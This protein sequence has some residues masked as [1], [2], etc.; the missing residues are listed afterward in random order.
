MNLG[1]FSGGAV[2]LS[3][4]RGTF[5]MPGAGAPSVGYP[6]AWERR[7][8]GVGNMK[9]WFVLATAPLLSCATALADVTFYSNNFESGVVGPEWSG[10]T[11]A[12]WHQNFTWFNGRYSGESISLH[13]LAPTDDVENP[14][15]RQYFLTF[16]L[17]I[18]DS[19]DG[20]W[21]D[22]GPDRFMVEVNNEMLFNE[23]FSNQNNTQSFRGPDTG[24]FDMGFARFDDA[25][26]RD[27]VIPFNIDAG[28]EL[29]FRFSTTPLQGLWDESWGIDNVRVS[30]RVVPGP[31][32]AAMFGLAALGLARRRR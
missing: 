27:V 22:F 28:G 18:L 11:R 4:R 1:G 15:E 6:G 30:Y 9:T 31:G 25:I 3:A 32:A 16:D 29:T 19:W 8:R 21:P 20:D 26:Y 24:R 10:P 13:L 2:A 5:V 12:T 14:N 7:G 23:L 17:F